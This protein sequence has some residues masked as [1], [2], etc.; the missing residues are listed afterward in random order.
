MDLCLNASSKTVVPELIDFVKCYKHVCHGKQCKTGDN[1]C[2]GECIWSRCAGFAVKCNADKK[3]GGKSC[4]TAWA[5]TDSCKGD[6][7][8]ECMSGC[9]KQLSKSAQTDYD[10]LWYCLANSNAKQ[11]WADCLDESLL[12]VSGG[13]TGKNSCVEVSVCDSKCPKG[14]NGDK[15]PCTSAC[16]GKG[17]KAAQGQYAKLLKCIYT[18]QNTGGDPGGTCGNDVVACAGAKPDG[19]KGTLG[20]QEISGCEKNCKKAA[21][22]KDEA[23]AMQCLAKASKT[24]ALKWWKLAMCYGGCGGKCKDSKDPKCNENCVKKDCKQQTLDCLS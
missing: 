8:I 3:S 20:C 22:G 24:E 7:A 14:P 2:L 21:N 11:A 23:C 12:C 9:Y 1:K 13:T 5:C 10:K 18:V 15:F 6:K 16:Y 17:T 4:A 19:T